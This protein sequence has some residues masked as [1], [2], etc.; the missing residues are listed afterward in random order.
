MI[1][2]IIIFIPWYTY[3]IAAI[4]W[5]RKMNRGDIT[6]LTDRQ[7]V[8]EIIYSTVEILVCKHCFHMWTISR[9]N[10][11]EHIHNSAQVS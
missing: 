4:V 11:T 1:Y 9:I 3:S 7:S 6:Y 10:Y 5:P 2:F 8:F